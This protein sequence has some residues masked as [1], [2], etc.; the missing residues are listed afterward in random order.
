MLFERQRDVDLVDALALA[1]LAR[2]G[3]RAE[4]R[5]AAV[6]EMVPAGAIV[7]EAD[8]LVAHL[9]VAE[10]LV[11]DQAAQF[12]RADDQ[13]ALEADARAPA[14]LER[15]A[16]DLPRRVGEHDVQH[17]E[18]R[19]DDLGHLERAPVLHV[20]RHVVRLEV[21][22]GDHAEDDGDDA[23]DEHREEVV[24]AR[25]VPAQAV[26]AL[27]VERHRHEHRHER[28]HDEVLLERR[29]AL[30][31]GDQV[32]F[33]PQHVGAKEGRDAK[34]RVRHDVIDGERAFVA[35][36]HEFSAVARRAHLVTFDYSLSGEE[37]RTVT[38]GRAADGPRSPR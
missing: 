29:D 24:D 15:L 1:D 10:D 31:D 26:Q 21:E 2:L 22:R 36:D 38:S 19:P 37:H 18:Q 28:Q 34:Q 14:A 32:R 35:F 8:D 12:A 30:G 7:D 13:D 23:A 5:K 6:A 25:T 20:G 33:E 9:A 3:R 11:R 27:E 4:Q 16:H 17:Q